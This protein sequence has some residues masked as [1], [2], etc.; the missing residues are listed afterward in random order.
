MPSAPP[1]LIDQPR[2]IE[3]GG[4]ERLV[5]PGLPVSFLSSIFLLEPLLCDHCCVASFQESLSWYRPYP[6][7]KSFTA[8]FPSF[9]Y[10]LPPFQIRPLWGSFSHLPPVLKSSLVTRP[11]APLLGFFFSFVATIRSSHGILVRV[12]NCWFGGR[13]LDPK[14]SPIT[15][16]PLEYVLK[17][18]HTS[19]PPPFLC[20]AIP[21]LAVCFITAGNP[22]C[23][24]TFHPNHG[25]GMLSC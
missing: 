8:S 12:I 7:K 23:P 3:P 19:P 1:P 6:I 20:E 25:T 24:M 4:G 17:I 10:L 14:H 2:I 18:T 22:R 15:P 9:F 16:L 11:P 13:I 5:A 21:R